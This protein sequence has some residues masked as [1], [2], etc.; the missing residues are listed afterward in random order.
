V[1]SCSFIR[2]YVKEGLETVEFD[3]ARWSMTDLIQEY[4]MYEA[5]GEEDEKK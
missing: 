1:R 4:D 2:W 5:A 3:E